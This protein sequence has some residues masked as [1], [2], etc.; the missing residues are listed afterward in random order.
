[1]FIDRFVRLLPRTG[2]KKAVENL[3]KGDYRK[4][5]RAFEDYLE[6]Q[7]GVRKSN[8][9]EMVRMYLVEAYIEYA[10]QL[11][12][13]GRD[14]RAAEILEK[15][16]RIEPLYADVHY[17]LARVYDRIGR[18][19][20]SRNQ[21]RK[22]LDINQNF[23]RARVMLARSCAADG[24]SA[25]AIEQMEVC[26][27]I[28]PGFLADSVADVVDKIRRGI[29]TADLADEFRRLLEE[30]PSSSQVSKQIALEA[31]QNGDYDFALSEIKKCLSMHP[32]YPDLHNLLGIAYANKGM[33]DDAV[34]E[35][36]TAL[37]IH[38]EYLKAR[39]NLALTLFEKGVR[40]EAVTHLERVLSLDPENELARNLMEEVR[41]VHKR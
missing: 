26:L 15:A 23:F 20:D 9:H 33:T 12:E 18:R 27:R 39:L 7:G 19:L 2:L 37:K 31:I 35:F 3:N 8:D 25:E 16:I 13:G 40:D 14:E 6:R 5:C 28:A 11:E 38:P 30:K 32:N 24:E 22:A 41:P 17:T 29:S 36:E 1:M 21:L 4:A 10:K 34:M